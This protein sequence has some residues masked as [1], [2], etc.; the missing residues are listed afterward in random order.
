MLFSSNEFIFR[1]L[2]LFMLVYVLAQDR[3]RNG[4]LLAGSLIFYGIGEPRFV[5]IMIASVIINYGLFRCL[6]QKRNKILLSITIL[7]NASILGWFKYLNFGIENLNALLGKEWTLPFEIA[8]PI[9]ISFYTF[10]ILS[11]QVDCF[12]GKIKRKVSFLEFATY[13]CMFPQLVAGPIVLFDEVEP[14]LRKKEVTV[15]KIEDGFKW[16]TFGL[17]LKVLLANSIYTLWNTILSAGN[18]WSWCIRCL[19][20]CSFLHLPN[21]L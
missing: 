11:F 5:W 16:F 15:E 4:I 13:I 7:L 12:K 10:Q 6:Y 14:Q 8:L 9:G 17:G 18:S 19:A 1:F 2:I 20:W 21:L 3:Y